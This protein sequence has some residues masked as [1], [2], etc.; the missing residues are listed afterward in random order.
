MKTIR[1]LQPLLLLAAWLTV[2]RA[3]QAAV[4]PNGL[5]ADG[6]VLQQGMPV[7][8]WG[9]AA[10]GEKVTVK[11]QGQEVSTTAQK[12]RW[13]VKLKPL[14]P[15]GPF[16]MT[17]T[18]ANTVELKDL[19]VGEVW[20]CSGQSN[21]AF[22]LYSAENAKDAIA[23]SDD[24]LLHLCTVKTTRGD[25]PQSEAPVSWRYL[26]RTGHGF[27]NNFSAVG[28]FFG[29][30]LRKALN[31]PVGLIHA[32]VGA[33]AIG[34]WTDSKT[35]ESLPPAMSK[36]IIAEMQNNK[37][38]LYNGMIAPLQPFAMRGVIWNQGESDQ[39]HTDYYQTM[40]PAMIKSWRA[41][42]GQ[43][44]FPFLFAQALPNDRWVP[45]LRE[46]QLL[47]WQRTTNTAMTVNLDCGDPI[48]IHPP[49]KEPL[50]IRFALAARAIAYGEKI[51]YSGPIYESM[52]VVGNHIVLSFQ[53]VG[54]GLVA[55]D[56]ALKGF[57]IAGADG[58]FVKAE[59][60][61]ECPT[62]VV[63]S[64]AVANPT[65]VRYAWASTPDANLCNQEG[66]LASPFRTDRP[67]LK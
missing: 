28:Y 50:G 31:V 61:I 4:T 6:A 19:L 46:A 64:P 37:G 59:A 16:T 55:K 60:R 7:P 11:F 1:S 66:L 47:V 49:K 39:H 32:S 62:V 63:S 51:E 17:I 14:Q 41:A 13:L 38:V 54:T 26:T 42:W 15:G 36:E 67:V 29:R 25:T 20:L 52:K 9:T 65:A 44:D 12:G 56:G 23:A 57:T 3:T 43:G 8:V 18:G 24:P 53:H 2:G 48:E 40:L 58:K 5:F 35:L 27:A 10:D 30:D 34:W 45:E 33:T 21:M 22:Q